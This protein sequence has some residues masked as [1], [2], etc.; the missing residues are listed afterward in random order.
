[1]KKSANK[2]KKQLGKTLHAKR[3]QTT[4]I[5]SA[6]ACPFP[7]FEGTVGADKKDSILANQNS[8]QNKRHA[9]RAAHAGDG[10]IP[11]RA[12]H[13]AKTRIDYADDHGNHNRMRK[14]FRKH[15]R[16]GSGNGK[17]GNYQNAAD[18]IESQ[19]ACHGDQ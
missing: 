18:V 9:D 15:A 17:K 7:F 6:S 2:Y 14:L 8:Q 1:M 4:D 3:R 12:Q 19:N 5:F 13:I 16:K 10:H 11:E